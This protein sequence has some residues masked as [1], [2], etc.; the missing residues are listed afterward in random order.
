MPVQTSRIGEEMKW[1]D[2]LPDRGQ[3]TLPG[4]A[5]TAGLC[6]VVFAVFVTKVGSVLVGGRILNISEYIKGS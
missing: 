6:N 1:I 3:V 4:V 2:L 5:V